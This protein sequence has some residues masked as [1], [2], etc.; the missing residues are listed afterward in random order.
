MCPF[1][2]YPRTDNH[3]SYSFQFNFGAN[4]G[5]PADGTFRIQF[6]GQE[7]YAVDANA[8]DV[9]AKQELRFIVAAFVFP[10]RCRI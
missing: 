9:S 6:N 3:Y 8:N 7:S 1:G 4:D 10:A 2:D 5:A